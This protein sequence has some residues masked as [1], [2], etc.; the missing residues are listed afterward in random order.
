MPAVKSLTESGFASPRTKPAKWAL[1]L[2]G[3]LLA[4]QDTAV[5]TE[6]TVY[7]VTITVGA[8]VVQINESVFDE[9]SFADLPYPPELNVAEIW[10]TNAPV[11]SCRPT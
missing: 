9:W 7:F 2:P 5:P 11:E 10:P 8:L 4:K 6:P 3:I 1:C